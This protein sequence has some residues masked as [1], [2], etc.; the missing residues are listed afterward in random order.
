MKIAAVEEKTGLTRA[1]IRFYESEGL[2]HPGRAENGYRDY[3]EDNVETLLKIKLLRKLQVSLEEIRAVQAGTASLEEILERQARRLGQQIR[4]LERAREVCRAICADGADYGHMDALRYLALLER[5]GDSEPWQKWDQIQETPHPWRRFFARFLDG[6]IYNMVVVVVWFALLHHYPTGSTGEAVLLFVVPVILML[7]LEPLWLYLW[8]T[9]PGKWLMGISVHTWDGR[10][11][12]WSQGLDRT[13]YCMLWGTGFS[14]PIFNFYRLYR[15]YCQCT[16]G[17]MPWDEDLNI[18]CK[19]PGPRRTAGMVCAFVLLLALILPV[20]RIVSLPPNRGE[21]TVEE[22]AENYNYYTDALVGDNWYLDGQ[23]RWEE[24][25]GDFTVIQ[26]PSPASVT[27]PAFEYT[28]KDGVLTG[29]SY[30]ISGTDGWVTNYDQPLHLAVMSF[31]G[32]QKQL[33]VLTG[34][35]NRLSHRL[36]EASTGSFSETWYGVN[37]RWTL[38]T[39]GYQVYE[40]YLIPADEDTGGTYR[41]SLELKLT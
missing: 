14:T 13:W 16:D 4:Q 1:N 32:A 20:A 38:E 37:I 11:L 24:D 21:L 28:V 31:V 30:E 12:T 18:A 3:T 40:S 35:F 33:P 9:T 15:S 34:D 2:L 26:T 39:E 19:D 22:F 8:G 6:M 10:R 23:G 36:S 5:G 27:R 7:V 17:Q 25:T 41:I 29:L